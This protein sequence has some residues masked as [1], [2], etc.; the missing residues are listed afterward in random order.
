M[1]PTRAD[2]VLRLPNTPAFDARPRV[3]AVDDAPAEEVSGGRRVAPISRHA[4][5]GFAEQQSEPGTGRDEPRRR[6]QRQTELESDWQQDHAVSRPPPPTDDGLHRG[7][8]G[9]GPATPV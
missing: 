8:L 4:L 2:V 6:R 9:A 7:Q 3:E 5:S 1:A